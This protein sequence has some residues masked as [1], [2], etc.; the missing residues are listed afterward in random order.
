MNGKSH[1]SAGYT[2]TEL[3]IVVTIM[4]ILIAIALPVAKSAIE[5]SKVRESS[6]LLSSYFAMAKTRAAVTGRPCGV[7]FQVDP[8]I[9]GGTS[10]YQATQMY[11]AEVAA[12][13]GG[14]TVGA[15]AVFEPDM[16][17]TP[18]TY[19]LAFPATASDAAERAIVE[20]LI[21]KGE[22]FIVRFD[23]KGDWFNVQRDSSTGK[24]K[25]STQPP[26][27]SLQSASLSGSATPP[28]SGSFPFQIL[29]SPRRVGQPRELAAGTCIDLAYCGSGINGTEFNDPTAYAAV[30]SLVVMFNAG[31]S[32]A[33]YYKAS[34]TPTVA[35][36]SLHFLVGRPEK[37]N[38]PSGANANHASGLNMYDPNTSNLAD[39]TSIWVS[40]GRLTGSVTSTE[41]MPDYTVVSTP[42]STTDK[43][44]YL[45]SAREAA[46]N[47]DQMGGR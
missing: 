37:V 11:L 41:N 44:K 18:P 13:Y 4:V 47:R 25:L 28:I 6:R 9:G 2:L 38:P 27:S 20:S 35:G 34:G 26:S 30:P 21:D 31:G 45:A 32:L 10:A 15:E 5:D 40:I 3:L 14:S 43:Q 23:Y 36:G 46:T 17:T 12:P 19:Y 8:I 29:R 22:H 42:T 16:G 7:A 33:G 24:F 1:K 39:P